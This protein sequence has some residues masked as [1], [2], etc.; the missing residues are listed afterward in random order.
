MNRDLLDFPDRTLGETRLRALLG[1]AAEALWTADAD[2]HVTEQHPS[3]LALTG[4]TRE[5]S[6][7]S[8]WLGAIHPDDR[9]RTAHAW[10]RAVA[11][12]TAYDCL[13]RVRCADGT[14][15]TLRSRGVPLRADD[16]RVHE[17]I[18]VYV[19]IGDFDERF[20]IQSQLLDLASDAMI[21]KDASHRVKAWLG[22]AP[23][24]YGFPAADAVGRAVRDLLHLEGDEDVPRALAD[25][26]QWEGEMT[27]RRAD[28]SPLVV[29]SRQ[30]ALRDPDVIVEVDADVTARREALEALSRLRGANEALESF[31]ST[32]AHELRTPLRALHG[33]ATQLLEA[34]GQHLDAAGR[35]YLRRI[36][37]A[38]TRMDRLVRDLL[39]LGRLQGASLDLETLD[40]A[41]VT[42][43]VLRELGEEV[44]RA[45]ITVDVCGAV[46]AHRA[47]LERVLANLIEN[48]VKYA[49][50]GRTPRV[51]L[52]TVADDGSVTVLVDDDG[53]GIPEDR[54]AD[55][56]A[57]FVRLDRDAHLPG[58]GLGLALARQG[59]RRMNAHLSV[60]ASPLGG[61]RFALSLPAP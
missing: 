29:H 14:Y 46:L 5:Q 3:W 55:V 13:H 41:V 54:E 59:A 9:V 42:A 44:N 23:A 30:R 12:G 18:G 51:R 61:A 26:Q 1:L 49:G 27:A 35:A 48:A 57:P 17:W 34:H 45:E 47:T 8:G 53:P 20:K 2:G 25:E 38:A 40:L 6:L 10:S 58:A 32:V 31:A 19:D 28:G 33:F 36:T 52:S 4:Q 37:N 56:F 11:R 39:A 43:D 15:R 7:G 21:V 60:A 16:G 22:G 24:V 50:E